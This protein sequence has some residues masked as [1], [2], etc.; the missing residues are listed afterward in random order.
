MYCS[1]YYCF[2]RFLFHCICVCTFSVSL[3]FLSLLFLCMCCCCCCIF[4]FFCFFLVFVFVPFPC[5][6]LVFC[7]VQ[8]FYNFVPVFALFLSVT[9][10]ISLFVSLHFFLSICLPCPCP[11]SPPLS[12]HLKRPATNQ[13]SRARKPSNQSART[14]KSIENTRLMATV[15]SSRA[16]RQ[17]HEPPPAP[18]LTPTA[19]LEK[20]VQ[21]SY[22]CHSLV[23]SSGHLARNST[24]HSALQECNIT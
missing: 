1:C 16:A 6:F 19:L 14:H 2:F 18:T 11:S 7:F 24:E 9:L 8:L 3:Y 13:Q 15:Q 22:R 5:A 23:F 20:R 21:Y 12:L 10:S 17:H 4:C